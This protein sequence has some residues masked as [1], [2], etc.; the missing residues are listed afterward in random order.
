MNKT[1]FV[2]KE[3]ADAETRV[4]ASPDTVK[5]LKGLGFDVVMLPMFNNDQVPA[6][7]RYS[8]AQSPE[9][10]ILQAPASWVRD[11]TPDL[12]DLET[13]WVEEQ[14]YEALCLLYVALTR[15]KRSL[16]VFLPEE[17]AS[18]TPAEAESW[19]SPANLIRQ[20]IPEEEFYEGDPAWVKEIEPRKKAP[21]SKVTL[22]E[23]IPLCERSTP[24]GTNDNRRQMLS[25]WWPRRRQPMMPRLRM[26][27]ST[28]S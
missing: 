22:G 23:S 5:K 14:R 18:R 28:A 17:P 4:A 24:S 16:N 26:A 8:V 6:R 27:T 9:G 13:G 20:S 1:L 3:T 11:L 15:A 2:P 7:N 25:S 12:R 19:A 21:V 10:W